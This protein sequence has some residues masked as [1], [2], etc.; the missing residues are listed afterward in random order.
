M[1]K[2]SVVIRILR[3][4]LLRKL[5]LR[6]EAKT[7]R[8]FVKKQICDKFLLF[9]AKFSRIEFFILLD[10]LLSLT[11]YVGNPVA[12]KVYCVVNISSFKVKL[13][14]PFILYL[15]GYFSNQIVLCLMFKYGHQYHHRERKRRGKAYL[16]CTL[17]ITD[18]PII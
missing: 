11:R 4:F 7:M 16:R 12:F 1:W 5:K 2:C 15:V 17:Y 13:I 8:S 9:F 14:S 3:I 6:K 10:T 18:H